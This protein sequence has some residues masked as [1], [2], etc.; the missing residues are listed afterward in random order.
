MYRAKKPLKNIHS[1]LKEIGP[2][3]GLQIIKISDNI[4]FIL[5][6][7]LWAFIYTANE[8]VDG[9]SKC[10]LN[11]EQ[12]SDEL[13]ENKSKFENYIENSF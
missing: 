13:I 9:H 10:N 5:F 2:D 8:Q 4:I 3:S 11:D 6:F 1:R 7:R 12:S